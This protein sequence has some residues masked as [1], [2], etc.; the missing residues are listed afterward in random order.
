MS[1]ALSFIKDFVAP[2]SQLGH[3]IKLEN[4]AQIKKLAK[5]VQ[6][7]PSRSKVRSVCGF[8]H[9]R[10]I[11]TGCLVVRSL[12]PPIFQALHC[13]DMEVL[14][15]VLENTPTKSVVLYEIVFKSHLIHTAKKKECSVLEYNPIDYWLEFNV[16]DMIDGCEDSDFFAKYKLLR[17]YF[18]LSESAQT[19]IDQYMCFTGV[20]Q[21]EDEESAIQQCHEQRE[22]ILENLEQSTKSTHRRI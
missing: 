4:I 7:L 20:R 3:Y 1:K 13:S 17:K 14:K 5:R 15:T 18:P 12:P 22:R 10:E 21:W 11:V 6:R 16:D 8:D 19:E 9:D 2:H